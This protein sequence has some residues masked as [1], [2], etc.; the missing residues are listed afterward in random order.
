MK[1]VNPVDMGFSTYQT[2]PYFESGYFALPE[3]LHISSL[4]HLP[5]PLTRA[6]IEIH[7]TYCLP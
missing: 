3:T 6:P 2:V 1:A 7:A 4:M 5:C